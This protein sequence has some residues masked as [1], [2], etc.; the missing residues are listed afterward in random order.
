[1]SFTCL[2]LSGRSSNVTFFVVIK[3]GGEE[4]VKNL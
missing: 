2:V 4:D 1:M 3:R